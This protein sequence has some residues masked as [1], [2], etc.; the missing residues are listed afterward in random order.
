[1][2]LSAAMKQMSSMINVMV[3]VLTAIAGI[4]LLEMCIRDRGSPAELYARKGLYAHMVDLQSTSQSWTCLLYTSYD[5]VLYRDACC[6]C[7]DYRFVERGF[8]LW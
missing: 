6:S 8:L 4:S 1:M 2:S 3:G 5:T 7:A